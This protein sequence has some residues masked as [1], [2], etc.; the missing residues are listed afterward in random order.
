MI[1]ERI[2]TYAN[3]ALCVVKVYTDDGVYGVGQTAPFDADITALIVHRRMAPIYLGKDPRRMEELAREAIFG[4][5][6]HK[7]MGSHLYRALAGV[8]TALWDIAGKVAGKPVCALI[9]GQPRPLAVYGSSMLRSITPEAEAERLVKIRAENGTTA[10]KIRIGQECGGNDDAQPGR[11]E[12]IIRTVREKL[13]DGACLLADANSGYTPER[14]I[15]IGRMLEANG[16]SHFEEPC[17]W[18]EFASTAKVREALTMD[19]AGGEEV[20]DEH[21]W[22]TIIDRPAVD[23]VQPDVCYTGGF[24][25]LLWVARQAEARALPC[26]PHSANHSLLF[27]FTLHLMA[28]IPN[29]GP[30]VESSIEDDRRMRDLY[31]PWPQVR[32]GVVNMPTGPGWGV[33]VNGDWLKKATCQ[34]STKSR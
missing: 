22:R 11:T 32:N 7:F 13:G 6:N 14:A 3:D 5:S 33:E 26:T 2:E 30:R 25:R 17:P 20:F 34:V 29:A 8:D 28:A 19:V 21:H 27:V 15:E 1:I 10:F 31:T 12:A 23:I 16:Y 9:G 24:S 18:W 4:A